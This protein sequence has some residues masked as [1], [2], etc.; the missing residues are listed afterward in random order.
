M[1]NEHVL[2]ER[3]QLEHLNRVLR[4]IR[5]VNQLIVREKDRERL[6]RQACELLVE[7]RGFNGAWI[8]LPG[9]PE[10]QFKSV[11]EAA[12]VGKSITQIGGQINVNKAF[13]DML[14]YT[15]EELRNK[16]WQELTPAD[17]IEPIQARL[18]PLLEGRE[19]STR[20][21]KRYIH[22]NGDLA[23]ADVSVAMQRDAGGRPLYFIA[24]VIDITA[25]IRAE[26]ERQ[27]AQ[28]AL[29]ASE[30]RY[31]RLFESAKDGILILDAESGMILDVNPF[32]V[33]LL[34]F[35]HEQF[36]G[37]A[38]WELGAFTDIIA[39]QAN[40]VELQQ[41]E[42][43][44]YEDMPLETAAGRRI[45]V[46]FVSNVYQVNH[47]RVIQCNVRD[48]TARK[49]AEAQLNEQLDELRRWHAATLGREGRIMELKREVNDLLSQAGQPPRYPSAT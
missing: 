48:I 2:Q 20:F 10:E 33:E 11:F 18:A 43:I 16:T 23:W 42:Y 40:F 34:G 36:L 15:Q 14:G 1:Q 19:D 25:R 9:E 32:L 17:E 45:H 37:K 30:V 13:A 31:R 3:T 38:V 8:A 27:Q 22:K 4:A 49:Q 41:K 5:N 6:I 39:N 28:E 44:R 12:N 24:T 29:R 26:T 21:N 46:E 7:T 35:S 47:R